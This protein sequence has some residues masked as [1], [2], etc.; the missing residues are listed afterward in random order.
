MWAAWV[1]AMITAFFL[2]K[3]FQNTFVGQNGPKPEICWVPQKSFPLLNDNNINNNK[4]KEY[5]AYR[6]NL[7]IFEKLRLGG[8]VI[9]Q[10]EIKCIF[11]CDKMHEAS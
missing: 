6:F 3:S 8:G 5:L 9:V 1:K 7:H 11:F 4:V 2:T 10:H